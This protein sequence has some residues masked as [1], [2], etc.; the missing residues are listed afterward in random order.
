MAVRCRGVGYVSTILAVALGVALAVA[1]AGLVLAYLSA[2]SRGA[3]TRTR[4]PAVLRKRDSH[5]E[6]ELREAQDEIRRTRHLATLSETY[7]LE[8]LLA[9]VLQ[10]SASLADADAAAVALWPEGGPA[11][12]KAT[13]LPPE[14]AHA[15]LRGW[16]T[17]GRAR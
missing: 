17:Q 3:S 4:R 11:V 14:E 2:R 9:R 8:E 1:L 7:D 10:A 12:V 6:E 5:L 15:V 16:Q 13:N